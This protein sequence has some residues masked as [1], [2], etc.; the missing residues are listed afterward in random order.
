MESRKKMR[1]DV[2]DGGV[3][4]GCSGSLKA[5]RRED[6]PRLGLQQVDRKRGP[7]QR[8]RDGSSTT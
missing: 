4:I 8:D 6:S 1:L 2:V 3:L 5:G 7:H